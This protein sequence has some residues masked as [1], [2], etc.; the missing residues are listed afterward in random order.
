MSIPILADCH[1][2]HPPIAHTDNRVNKWRNKSPV[3]YIPQPAT[4]NTR[5]HQQIEGTTLISEDFTG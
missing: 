2:K 1:C 5:A 4:V 3:L